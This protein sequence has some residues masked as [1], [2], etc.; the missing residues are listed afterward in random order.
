MT[1]LYD[2]PSAAGAFR[3]LAER[4]GELHRIPHGGLGPGGEQLSVDV[5]LIGPADARRCVV[6][7]SGLHGVEGVAGSAIQRAW[8]EAYRGGDTRLVMVH[9][10]NPFG[11]AWQRRVE[12]DNIDLNRNFLPA[13]EPYRGAP[14][15][16]DRVGGWLAP[17]RP[18]S[19]LDPLLPKALVALARMGRRPL[20]QAVGG[21]QYENERGLFYGGSGPA[22][23]QPL[24]REALPAWTKGAAEVLH[25]DIHTGLGRSGELQLL[26]P[27]LQ[28][29]PA[30][31]ELVARFG[32]DARPALAAVRHYRVQGGLGPWCEALLPDVRYTLCA[33]EFGSVSSTA[34][35]SALHQENRAWFWGGRGD[36]PSAW[37]RDR[38]SHAFA[39]LS[40]SW[41][42][43]VLERG[44]HLIDQALEG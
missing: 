42:R 2:W 9:L 13:G 33:A 15:Q 28:G 44:I 24:L 39:P 43:R 6:V 20:L 35:L 12:Q 19:R 16:W 36:R 26:L 34:V 10:L 14:P 1:W 8:L 29:T 21:G 7:S 11:F 4:H 30:A 38:L 18:A 3:A 22:S 31:D 5:A 40:Q 23:L 27:R 17:E 32:P 25:L 41:R 37:A